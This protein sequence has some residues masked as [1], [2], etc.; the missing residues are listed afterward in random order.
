[1]IL[2]IL[3]LFLNYLRYTHRQ[4]INILSGPALQA[5]PVKMTTPPR[6]LRHTA[7]A[8]LTVFRINNLF[9]IASLKIPKKSSFLS[10]S[11]CP[12]LRTK[13]KKQLCFSRH[14]NLTY[15]GCGCDMTKNLI[16]SHYIS[17]RL[18]GG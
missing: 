18:A 15:N 5:V 2:K 6:K 1:M 11:F 9:I 7:K 17:G 12:M 10:T 4:R 8:S 14:Q 3:R 13:P 16:T